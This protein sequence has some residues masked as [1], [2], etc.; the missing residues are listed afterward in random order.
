MSIKLGG[1]ATIF[2]S[3]LLI[4]S[5]FPKVRYKLGVLQVKKCYNII[6]HLQYKEVA[7]IGWYQHP[8]S[9]GPSEPI[10]AYNQPK[11]SMMVECLVSSY[12]L[13]SLIINIRHR[14]K[15]NTCRRLDIDAGNYYP[16]NS[17]LLKLVLVDLNTLTNNS[18]NSSKWTTQIIQSYW[19]TP[20]Y[21]NDFRRH[22]FWLLI[23]ADIFK[24]RLHKCSGNL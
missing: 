17:Q 14:T 12:I 23:E 7:Y 5:F 11:I 19:S 6:V 16:T 10:T 3:T 18:I 13:C 21:K 24:G 15:S 20:H 22:P 1:S 2:F 4:L 9:L 8:P